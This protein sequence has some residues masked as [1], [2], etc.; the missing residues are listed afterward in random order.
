[1]C[2]SKKGDS[3]QAYVGDITGLVP[4]HNNEMTITIKIIK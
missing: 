2:K 4:D 1:M 3:V